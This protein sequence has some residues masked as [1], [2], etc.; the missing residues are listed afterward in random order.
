[1][2]AVPA[3]SIEPLAKDH[4]R[5]PFTCG[6]EPL[7]RYLQTQV[8]QDQKSRVAAA[9]MLTEPPDRRVLGFYT[10]SSS[11]IQLDGLPEKLAKKLPKYPQLPATLLG[12]L[13][14]DVTARGKRY[15]ELL[16]MDALRRSLEAA[17]EIGAMAVIVDAKDASAAAFYAQYGFETLPEHERRMFLPMGQVAVLFS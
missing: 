5:K 4:D 11:T 13:A 3:P 12:R 17:T 8:S 1:M 10:L 14:V 16:L 6:A 9:F 7:D 2:A 15:G